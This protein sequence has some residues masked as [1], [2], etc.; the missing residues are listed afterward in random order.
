MHWFELQKY[1]KQ[2]VLLL[3]IVV[4]LLG[5]YVASA[6]LGRMDTMTGINPA[7]FWRHPDYRAQE[8][9]VPT[10][11]V[12]EAWAQERQQFY[13]D[14]VD[15][16]GMTLEESRAQI[17]NY[18]WID[19]SAE[20]ALANKYDIDY[21]RGVLPDAVFDRYAWELERLYLQLRHLIPMAADPLAYVQADEAIRDLNGVP[22]YEMRGYTAAQQ[23]DRWKTLERH[24]KDMVIRDG[25]CL[26]WDVLIGVMQYL[27]YTLGMT[28]LLVLGGLFSEE[29]RYDM[30]PI[31]RTTR[32]G[33]GTLLRTK[34]S[35][36]L[37]TAIGLWVLFQGTVLLAVALT[38]GLQG[39]RVTVLNRAV[40]PN[41][42]GLSWGKYYAIQSLFSLLGTLVFALMICVG[43][44]CL[45]LR[46]M[47]PVGLVLVVLTGV[48]VVKFSYQ[49][50]AL[51]L[52]EKFQVLTPTQLL[53]AYPAL[54]VYQ[55]YSLG[56]IQLQ[57]PLAMLLAV[58]LE[59]LAFLTVLYHREGGK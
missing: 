44:S 28:L 36:A 37:L 19:Y 52:V 14:L 12:N 26:G 58:V 54:Q 40:I 48:P 47:L 31:L 49:H 5:V 56:R 29:H 46:V 17:K 27:P 35:L 20:E 16:Y 34:L 43:S 38:Y 23:A 33:R 8:Q 53:S 9:Q 51:S 4:L 30:V 21:V 50:C 22:L 10:A 13:N 41:V 57:L 25:Y 42:Y 2:T 15:T 6:F 1:R 7:Y 32:K 18:D 55:S 24:Y 3:L 59:S 11:V 45:S 39:A